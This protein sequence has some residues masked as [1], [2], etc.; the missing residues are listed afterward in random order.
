MPLV[1]W[2]PHGQL[3]P[4]ALQPVALQ[5]RLPVLLVVEAHERESPTPPVG[6]HDDARV[7]HGHV[8]PGLVLRV[9]LEELQQLLGR[10][11]PVEV[12][13]VELADAHE[14]GGDVPGEVACDAVE[15]GAV[16]R[17]HVVGVGGDVEEAVAGLEPRVVA[18]GALDAA[19]LPLVPQVLRRDREEA[20]ALSARDVRLGQR[21]GGAS[22]AVRDVPL[23]VQR[24]GRDVGR[25]PLLDHVQSVEVLL[26]LPRRLVL[27]AKFGSLRRRGGRRRRL[28]GGGGGFHGG[29][30]DDGAR[31]RRGWQRRRRGEGEGARDGGEEAAD[32][33]RPHGWFW[34]GGNGDVTDYLLRG[35]KSENGGAY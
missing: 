2:F 17:G 9:P 3:P 5:R 28:G 24:H 12:A 23:R 8:L 34:A 13:H 35:T 7:A 32:G 31:S 1:V 14:I 26:H 33:G 6:A 30:D 10:R 22:P 20:L 4:V 19:S 27:L 21:Q 29:S 25:F 11:R 16:G 15:F 18:D